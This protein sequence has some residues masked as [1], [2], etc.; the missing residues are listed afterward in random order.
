MARDYPLKPFRETDQAKLRKVIADYP[1]ATVISPGEPWPAVTQLPLL[2]DQ[3]GKR[4]RG[5]LD[6]NN[7]HCERL[8]EGGSVYCVFSGPNH[9]MTPSIYPET[10]YPGWNYVA[11]H[12]KGRVTPI[13]DPGWLEALLLDTAKHNEPAGSGYT[14]TPAQ[15]NFSMLLTT[16]LG[17]EIEI[18]EMQG[19]F[20][21][22]QDKG[23]A[24]AELARQHLAEVLQHDVGDWL[25]EL[26][27][28]H[29]D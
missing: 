14:L 17:F 10:H 27:D 28:N 18:G 26:L 6:R 15:R 23:P 3:S 2:F 20:K 4:L 12:V 9:Y 1:L 5:H 13:E 22:A 16:I 7:P 25:A 29:N 21:L 24:N 8:L 11:V 19:I